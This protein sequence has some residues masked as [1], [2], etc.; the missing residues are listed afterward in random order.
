MFILDDQETEKLSDVLENIKRACASGRIALSEFKNIRYQ[1]NHVLGLIWNEEINNKFVNDGKF[2]QF[3][4]SLRSH[5]LTLTRPPNILKFKNFKQKILNFR[6][7]HPVKD[8]MLEILDDM[9][10]LIDSVE[11]LNN[12]DRSS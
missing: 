2:E 5:V 6:C 10:V 4:Y 7:N 12:V 8:K 9:Q 3:D 11:G 1:I